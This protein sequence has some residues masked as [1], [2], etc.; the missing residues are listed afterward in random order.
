MVHEGEHRIHFVV[1][2]S[3]MLNAVDDDRHEHTPAD[4][5]HEQHEESKG[6]RTECRCHLVEFFSIDILQCHFENRGSGFQ[7][8]R[9]A[10]HGGEKE[11][12]EQ[13]KKSD[14]DEGEHHAEVQ[15][16]SSRVLQGGDEQY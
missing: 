14:E 16:G 9:T 3:Q 12:I 1:R 7:D 11:C 4:K 8:T 5:D 15:Q 6:Q 2:L 10:L 13:A